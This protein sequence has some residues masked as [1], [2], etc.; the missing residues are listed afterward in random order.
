MHRQIQGDRSISSSSPFHK[1]QKGINDYMLSAKGDP[2]LVPLTVPGGP[3]KILR[4]LG[5]LQFQSCILKWLN[6][7]FFKIQSQFCQCLQKLLLY[8]NQIKR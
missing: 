4:F 8:Q 5:S 6:V 3:G 7:S 1:Q 2:I